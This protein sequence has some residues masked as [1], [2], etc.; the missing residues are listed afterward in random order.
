[1]VLLEVLIFLAPLVELEWDAPDSCPSSSAFEESVT[2]QADVSTEDEAPAVLKAWVVVR[3]RGEGRWELSLRMERE[4]KTESRTFEAQTCAAVAEVAAT[5]VSLRVVEWV[6]AAPLIPEPDAL[7]ASQPR[8]TPAEP[9]PE[10]EPVG[11]TEPRELKP[12]LGGAART[13]GPRHLR[14]A[15]RSC[16][17]S[18]RT[19]SRC[20]SRKTENAKRSWTASS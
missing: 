17:P 8:V 1:M 5:L 13:K 6:E 20:S 14:V 2:A 19:T 16:A 10:P 12:E 7:P 11:S 4:G 18:K 9:E 15:V 3:E